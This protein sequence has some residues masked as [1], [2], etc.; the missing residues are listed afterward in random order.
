LRE[1]GHDPRFI[2][3]QLAHSERSKTVASYNHA[4]YLPQRRALMQAWSDYLDKLRADTDA[5]VNGA[6]LP[7]ALRD[8]LLVQTA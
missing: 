4:E 8:E 3:L 5:E 7:F 2:E 1:Q 6:L